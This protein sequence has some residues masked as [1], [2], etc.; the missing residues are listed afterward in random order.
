LPTPV[1]PS[2][3]QALGGNGH[4]SL[5]WEPV[6]GAQS[7]V[8]KR[9]KPDG[10][11]TK[12]MVNLLEPAWV[13]RDAVAGPERTYLIS[14]VGRNGKSADSAPVTAAL[15]GEGL[16]APWALR[17]WG[18]D[19]SGK[20]AFGNGTL[21]LEAPESSSAWAWQTLTRDA[22]F[23]AHL[24]RGGAGSGI[25]VQRSLDPGSP[26]I[27]LGISAGGRGILSWGT[28]GDHAD[29]RENGERSAPC[30][31]KLTR[32]RERY[33]GAISADGVTWRVLGEASL[34]SL[35]GPVYAGLVTDSG[36]AEFDGISFPLA[37]PSLAGP[38]DSK[39]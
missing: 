12:I 36:E 1:P 33:S 3:I 23:L 17:A 18:K 38:G 27:F 20:A 7:Y 32:T 6:D 4:V 28:T 8:V 35:A 21:L 2:R 5:S 11:F 34:V 25:R 10:D 13:D 29:A 37:P 22:V 31:L 9:R 30:W 24:K 16:P 14:S 19:A 39:E 26:S 15:S